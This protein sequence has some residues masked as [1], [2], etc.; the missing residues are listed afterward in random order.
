MIM[1]TTLPGFHW[2]SSRRDFMMR[3]GNRGREEPAMRLTVVRF[4]TLMIAAASAGLALAP[5]RCDAQTAAFPEPR[6][7]L[8]DEATATPSLAFSPDGTMLVAGGDDGRIRLW[9]IS[10]GRLLAEGVQRGGLKLGDPALVV[11]SVAFSP[12]GRTV[13][14]VDWE[15]LFQMWT[16]RLGQGA[17]ALLKGDYLYH[18]LRVASSAS[19]TWAFSRDGR[20]LECDEEF[21]KVSLR[22]IGTGRFLAE[23]LPREGLMISR[24]T[25]LAMSRD[26]RILAVRGYHHE[27][28]GAKRER[29]T[30]EGVIQ[31]WDLGERKLRM[32]LRPDRDMMNERIM[33]FSPDATTLAV[34]GAAEVVLW[35]LNARQ[36]RVPLESAHVLASLAYSPDGEL[37]AI[38]G[39][40]GSLTIL[41]PAK[42]EKV[43]EFREPE[44][45]KSGA[46]RSVAFSWD[47]RRLATGAGGDGTIKLW[48][49]KELLLMKRGK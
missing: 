32:V 10:A 24:F 29:L 21:G 34:M 25:S 39:W 44:P 8:R 13:L 23:M 43:A 48:D 12:D 40:D 19:P 4:G 2:F 31:I 11:T 18:E 20:P 26:A 36:S 41:H 30:T 42:G 22:D 49:L 28:E 27:W 14:A 3:E 45:G 35:D 15:R 6:L 1:T 47:G 37:L 17:P 38:G 9:D 16:I 5:G 33:V 7:V 46:V